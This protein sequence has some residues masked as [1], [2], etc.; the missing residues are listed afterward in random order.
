[1]ASDNY[2]DSIVALDIDTGDVRWSF[3]YN[4]VDYWNIQLCPNQNNCGPNYKDF[5]FGQGPMLFTVNGVDAVGAGQ[6]G[7]LVHAVNR[8]NGQILWTKKVGEGTSGGG[9]LF[10]SSVDEKYIYVGNTNNWGQPWTLVDGSV[11]AGFQGYWSAL[12]KNTGDI[13]WQVCNPTGAKTNGPLTSTPGGLMFAGS[14]DSAGKVYALRSSDGEIMWQSE[15]GGSVGSGAALTGSYLIW[16]GG[17][18]KWS[19]CC[20]LLLLTL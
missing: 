14:L 16:G 18:S 2:V 10:G 4:G 7:G 8:D 13:V 17:Y 12:D 19:V 3:N 15:L 11:C 20:C 6:K 9:M 5:D 1:M